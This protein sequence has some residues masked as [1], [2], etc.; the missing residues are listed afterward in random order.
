M[1]KYIYFYDD[2]Q[3]FECDIVP[4]PVHLT[5]YLMWNVNDGPFWYAPQID[6]GINIPQW[7][8]IS[9]DEVPG[10]IRLLALLFR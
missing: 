2:G 5:A 3:S 7:R 1:S 6:R 8:S 4:D 9:A 10:G